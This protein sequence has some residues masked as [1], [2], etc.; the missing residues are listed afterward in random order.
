[1][2]T[3]TAHFFCGIAIILII[4]AAGCVAPPKAT[5]AAPGTNGYTGEVTTEPVP[6]TISYV[7][8][9]TPF[10]TATPSTPSG[11]HTLPP[12]TQNIE[13]IACLISSTRHTYVYN[14][15]AFSFN[16]SNPPMYIKYTIVNPLVIKGVKVVSGRAQSNTDTVP[17]SYFDPQSWFEITVRDKATGKIFLQDGFLNGH[18]DYTNRTLKV[19]N[20]G[21]LLIEM[22]GNRQVTADVGI[23]VKPEGNLDS[24]FDTN[25]T[26]CRN[27][28]YAMEVANK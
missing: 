4:A 16:L 13:D 24:T 21:D 11:I 7:T 23:W 1:M 10:E 14:K 9:A 20:K 8:E 25:S 6:T 19:L 22:E 3:E 12:V 15:T 26:T 2:K 28:I 18:Q 17:Y 5:T 27:F